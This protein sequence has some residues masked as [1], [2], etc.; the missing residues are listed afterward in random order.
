MTQLTFEYRVRDSLGKEHGG[1]I[2]A[3]DRDEAVQRLRRE[4]L[5]VLE[6]EEDA[7]PGLLAP[8]IRRTDVIY[9]TNQLAIMV[10]TGITLSVALQGI[11][12]QEPNATLRRVLMELKRGEQATTSEEITV[13]KSGPFDY[14]PE[15]RALL[16]DLMLKF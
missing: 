3:A 9:L 16:A 13:E 14:S 6:I 10:E 4:G 7:G 11:L 2:A 8:S 1:S 15:Y 12:E 5:Q